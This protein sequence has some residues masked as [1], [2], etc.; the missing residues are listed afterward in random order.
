MKAKILCLILTLA[1]LASLTAVMALGVSADNEYLQVCTDVVEINGVGHESTS[2]LPANEWFAQN[3]KGVITDEDGTVATFRVRGW[4]NPLDGGDLLGFGYTLNG[5]GVKW[6]ESLMADNAGLSGY[7]PKAE[8]F[9]VTLNLAYLPVGTYEFRLYA[10]T[11]HGFYEVE[12]E[13]FIFEKKSMGEYGNVALNKEVTA[14]VSMEA[15]FFGAA[16][17]TDGLVVPFESQTDP[18]GWTSGVG[19]PI[20]LQ[21][22]QEIWIYIDLDGKYE[23]GRVNVYPQ[24]FLDGAGFPSSF[25]FFAGMSMGDLAP[26]A[27]VE[28]VNESAADSFTH[29]VSMDFA[30]TQAQIVALRIDRASWLQEGDGSFLSEIGEIEVFGK[31]VPKATYTVTFKASGNVVDVV[32]YEEGAKTVTAPAVP[33]KEGCV[34]EW[35]DF[36]L[37][38][39]DIEVNAIYTVVTEPETDPVT[40]PETEA[41]T[42]PETEP[43]T[44]EA[45]QAPATEAVTEAPTEAGTQAPA[46]E[47]DTKAEEKS[48]CASVVS[49]A[50]VLVLAV[51]AAA[52]FGKRKD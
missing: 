30:P 27:S 18:L 28:G 38:N 36:K 45:T 6:D 16:M 39:K 34:G 14:D 41:V 3:Y 35:P 7:F 51:M 37:E 44:E 19:N 17:L 29:P 2:D 23:I 9:D 48:G 15:S 11:T 26:V 8:R 22:D 10:A 31:L 43:A 42:D 25:T 1:M 50:A 52:A 12:D 5:G 4:V 13:S 47:A 20:F 32:T 40:E 46:T 49:G 33:E 24:L 21:R